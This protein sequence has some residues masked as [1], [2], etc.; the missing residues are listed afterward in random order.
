MPIVID[1]A[2]ARAVF[3]N[4]LHL[5]RRYSLSAYDAAYLEL[6]IREEVALATLDTDLRKAATKAGF[7]LL[8]R[9]TN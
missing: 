2:T 8:E 3:G 4:T 7:K 1:S 9:T 5:A 6:A